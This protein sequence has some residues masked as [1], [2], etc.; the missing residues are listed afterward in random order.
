MKKL[1]LKSPAFEAN[2]KIPK[3]YTCQGEGFSPPLEIEGVPSE[4]KT[5]ALI[6]DDP[7]AVGGVFDHW[8]VWNI[9]ASISK[10]AENQTPPGVEGLNSGRRSG[11]YPP[12]P[13][14]GSHRYTFK[15][16]ALDTALDLSPKSRKKDLENAMEGH[17]VA[18]AELIGLYR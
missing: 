7:D 10:I 18:K 15:I 13:P 14:S 5:L 12:C 4:T 1:T 3:K 16:Y 9:P 6:M 11:Y 8:I 2:E 17:I